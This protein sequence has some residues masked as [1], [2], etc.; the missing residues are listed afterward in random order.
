MRNELDEKLK[1]LHVTE[2]SLAYEQ[3]RIFDGTAYTGLIWTILATSTL[4]Y[5]F[6]RL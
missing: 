1:E 2:G 5:V 4:F 3:K 6:K